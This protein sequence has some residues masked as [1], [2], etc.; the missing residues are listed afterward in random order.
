MIQTDKYEIG[1][2]DIHCIIGGRPFAL[3]MLVPK[4]GEIESEGS[5]LK[6]GV[7]PGMDGE[8]LEEPRAIYYVDS[9]MVA[10]YWETEP[11]E[12]DMAFSPPQGSYSKEKG[13]TPVGEADERFNCAGFALDTGE[14]ME[15]EDA[16][17]R[18]KTDTSFVPA[19]FEAMEPGKLYI[20]AYQF[21]FIKVM[22]TEEGMYR[23]LEKNG[24]SGIYEKTYKAADFAAEKLSSA[25][26]LYERKM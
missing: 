5:L 11:A 19:T 17:E 13:F 20:L 6:A 16:H 3:V 26:A 14:F 21:H 22:K 25:Y 8:D 12:E 2:L 23:T 24:I 7:L 18:L 4:A 1:D 10:D 9:K 15:P